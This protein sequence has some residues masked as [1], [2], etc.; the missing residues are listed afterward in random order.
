[1]RTGARIVDGDSFTPPTHCRCG[2]PIEGAKYVGA[3]ETSTPGDWLLLAN[4]RSC[5]TTIVEAGLNDASR[6]CACGDVVVGDCEEPKCVVGLSDGTLR[7]AHVDCAA[8]SLIGLRDCFEGLSHAQTYLDGL[9]AGP[10]VR[11]LVPRT[12]GEVRAAQGA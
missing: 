5:R 12:L 6:C 3:Q 8:T 4:C 10:V 11:R 9:A 7:I 2:E 1:M